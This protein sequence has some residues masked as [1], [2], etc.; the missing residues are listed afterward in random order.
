MVGTWQISNDNKAVATGSASS[1]SVSMSHAANA[2]V[3]VASSIRFSVG[4]TIS[5]VSVGGAAAAI[6]TALSN[7]T[8]RGEAWVIFRPS[9]STG[10]TVQVNLAT[11]NKQTFVAASFTG[12]K[13]VTPFIV[14]AQ[15]AT[16]TGT[17]SAVSTTKGGGAKTSASYK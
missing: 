14:Q 12:D 8:I 3:V 15:A 16:A 9:A 13:N 10:E 2:L 6:L 5:S 11:T 4:S 17:A 1:I 7:G